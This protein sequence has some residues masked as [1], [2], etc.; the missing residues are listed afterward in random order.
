MKR[1]GTMSVI[2]CLIFN[3]IHVITFHYDPAGPRMSV[4]LP[5]ESNCSYRNMTLSWHIMWQYQADNDLKSKSH[6]I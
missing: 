3:H 6:Y 1:Y 2:M 4:C 5:Y